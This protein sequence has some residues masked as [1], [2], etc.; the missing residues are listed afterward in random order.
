MYKRHIAWIIQITLIMIS[1]SGCI[2]A[3]VQRVSS[4]SR[5]I[6]K[7][8]LGLGEHWRK[9]QISIGS[10]GYEPV[11]LLA[12]S[13]RVIF[14][15]WT[16]RGDQLYVLDAASGEI[17]WKSQ[18]ESRFRPLAADA[19]RVYTITDWRICAY[20]L[21]NGQQLWKS[22]EMPSHSAYFLD[23]NGERLQARDTTK[24]K[25]YYLNVDTGAILDSASLSANDGSFLLAEFPQL[26]LH[27]Q[28]HI[29]QAVDKAT[30]Q[31]L[32]TTDIK[33]I[34]LTKSLP[35]LF[36]DI[37]LVGG[38]EWIYAIDT[39][40]GQVKWRNQEHPF[41]SNFAVMN[42]S[43]YALD[44]DARF[45]QYDIKTGQELGHI[46]FEPANTNVS[47]KRY[48]VAADGQ[49]LFISFSDSQEL[50]ALGP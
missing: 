39:Q 26:D 17:L 35:I 22:Q 1:L 20:D 10:L 45:I 42:G 19:K 28:H 9:S 18:E 2:S 32:W 29:L 5:H 44:Y 16:E 21:N 31:T 12:V 15:S 46:Q 47:E 49:M 4:E 37:L 36:E 34:G 27:T 41:A 38:E 30:Q 43:L 24:N 40:T 33:Y 25:V 3:G 13:S 8:T 6:D 50:I 14:V 48:W 23:L 11:N 7:N